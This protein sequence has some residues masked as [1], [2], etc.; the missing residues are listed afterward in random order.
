[1]EKI[2]QIV[3]VDLVVLL[4]P[5]L[6]YMLYDF[7][8]VGMVF[9]K[10]GTWLNTI[11]QTLAKPLGKCLKCFHVWIVIIS[12]IIIGISFFKFIILLSI[13]YVILVKLF[14]D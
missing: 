11:N 9:E 2:A 12:S 13:S 14:Y 4:L 8:Q 6:S 3:N 5:F 10:Y 1:M 7:M